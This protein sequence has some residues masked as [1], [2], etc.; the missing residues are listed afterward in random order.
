M[1]KI[2]FMANTLYSGGAERVLQTV[3]NYLDRGKYEITLYSLHRENIDRDIYIK[4][5]NYRVV[6]DKYSGYLEQHSCFA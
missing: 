4:P 6:F 1:R 2:L 3:L 5:F